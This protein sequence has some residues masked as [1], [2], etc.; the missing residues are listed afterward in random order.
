MNGKWDEYVEQ[1]K[2]K[3]EIF[4]ITLH[5]LQLKNRHSFSMTC[6]YSEVESN[7]SSGSSVP[8]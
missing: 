6:R 4:L 7:I 5:L 2:K 1:E 3:N 8:S